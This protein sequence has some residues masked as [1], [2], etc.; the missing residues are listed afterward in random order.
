MSPVPCPQ[1][2]PTSVQLSGAD[3]LFTSRA[4][5]ASHSLSRPSLDKFPE[6]SR[7]SAIGEAL[8]LRPVQLLRM[9]LTL[10][11]Q[12]FSGNLLRLPEIHQPPHTKWSSSVLWCL[13]QDLAPFNDAESG[14]FEGASSRLISGSS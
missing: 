5:Q 14:S 4:F 7:R 3:A 9:K 13:V 6:P 12:S 1:L 8:L 2:T 11:S 10:D